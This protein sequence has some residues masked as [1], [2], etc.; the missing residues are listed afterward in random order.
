MN[1]SFFKLS[2]CM[3][4]CGTEYPF[5]Y[6]QLLVPPSP[7]L[8]GQEEKL[9]K[10]KWPWLCTALR[11]NTQK[12]WCVINIVFLLKPKQSI[13]PDRMKKNNSVLAETKTRHNSKLWLE[14]HKYRCYRFFRK[15]REFA[16][17]YQQHILHGTSAAIGKLTVCLQKWLLLAAAF[18]YCFVSS[19]GPHQPASRVIC[20]N[21]SCIISDAASLPAHINI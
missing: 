13:I 7:S 10:L 3:M 9:R 2:F 14:T 11:S 21:F 4:P 5:G 8:A 6:S 17:L 1:S 19:N 16:Q 20:G 15:F 18:P 12:H